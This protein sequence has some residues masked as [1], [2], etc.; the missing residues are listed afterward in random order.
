MKKTFSIVKKFLFQRSS[1]RL[2]QKWKE[3][4]SA[5]ACLCVCVGV[6]VRVCGKERER[7]R[8]NEKVYST[9]DINEQIL[10]WHFYDGARREQSQ[11]LYAR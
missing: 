4:E 8:E 2:L 6:H 1:T 11:L 10:C 5:C 7:E 3:R 9:L